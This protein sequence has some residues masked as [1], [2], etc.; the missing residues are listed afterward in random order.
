MSSN[1]K[2]SVTGWID[3]VIAMIV[4]RDDSM[5][6]SLRSQRVPAR[7]VTV[8]LVAHPDPVRAIPHLG[9]LRVGAFI[10]YDD[11]AV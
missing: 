8:Y 6:L 5:A 3:R 7:V 2:I 9:S 10:I 4:V 11:L 1:G